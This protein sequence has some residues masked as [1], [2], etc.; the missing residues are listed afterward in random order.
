MWDVAKKKTL[1]TIKYAKGDYKCGSAAMLG[2]T[3]YISA[4]VCAGPDARGALYTA[5]GKKLAD[6]GGKDF[7]TYGTGGVQLDGSQWAFLEEGAMQCGYCV[8]GMIVTA[9]ALLDGVTDS[10]QTVLTG[11]KNADVLITAHA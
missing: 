11:L 6:V 4:S 1:A 3:V 8:P 9:T 2:D 10:A 5:K 7:G